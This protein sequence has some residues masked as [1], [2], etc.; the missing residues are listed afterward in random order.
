[1]I[2][3][4]VKLNIQPEFSKKFEEIFTESNNKIS[5]FPGCM[6]VK[7]LKDSSAENQF[8]TL[9]VWE[10]EEALNAY[11]KSD[12]FASIWP[13]VKTMFSQPAEAWSTIELPA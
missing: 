10:N 9:S 12:L 11:R 2:T 7:L 4:I 6:S 5:N 3:R 8:F 1:M 13:N